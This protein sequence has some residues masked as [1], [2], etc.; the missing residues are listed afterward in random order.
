MARVYKQSEGKRLD[1]PGRTSIEIVSGETGARG[2]TLRLVEIPVPTQGDSQRARHWHS[3][4]E[5]CIYVLSGRG[6]THAD[7]G[8]YPLEAGDT[9][10]M[11]AGEKHVTRNTGSQPLMLLCFFPVAG[12]AQAMEEPPSKRVL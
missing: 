3:D 9:M 12:L 1:L 8:E 11:P 10:L 7:S 5:E 2:M 4:T 6:T